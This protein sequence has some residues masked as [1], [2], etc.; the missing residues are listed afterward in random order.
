MNHPH[1]SKPNLAIPKALAVIIL[2]LSSIFT[3][4]AAYANSG[5]TQ[6]IDSLESNIMRGVASSSNEN[7]TALITS[8]DLSIRSGG[9][10]WDGTQ[11]QSQ[12][13]R[14]AAELD[15]VANSV[16]WTYPFG[17][18]MFSGVVH[19]S[20]RS[21]DSTGA[22]SEFKY[23]QF[24]QDSTPPFTSLSHDNPQLNRIEG[25]ASDATLTGQ[26]SGVERVELAIRSDNQYWNGSSFTP[27]YTRVVPTSTANDFASWQYDIS[28]LPRDSVYVVA[29]TSVDKAGN[30]Q[31][32][33][34]TIIITP[35]EPGNGNVEPPISF[36]TTAEATGVEGTASSNNGINRVELAISD[37]CGF[38]NGQEFDHTTYRRV[39]ASAYSRNGNSVNW[40]YNFPGALPSGTYSITSI[41]FDSAGAPQA[42]PYTSTVFTSN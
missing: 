11:F 19:V 4:S 29:A 21:I 30:W 1:H 25:N 41:A 35:E 5:I 23:F 32:P 40:S 36:I 3:Y 17:E 34:E 22:I 2:A 37:G 39:S 26:G 28:A 27:A 16:N 10:Y 20:L 38:W 18:A 13:A 8:V 24:S 7:G 15:T 31:V 33:F 14:V 42:A 12:W 9:R 6:N